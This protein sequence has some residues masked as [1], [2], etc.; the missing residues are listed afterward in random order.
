MEIDGAMRDIAIRVLRSRL[1]GAVSASAYN[2]VVQLAIQLASVPIL[3]GHLGLK[4]Y[5]IWL[6]LSTI[7]SY[8]AMADLGFASA[9]G[10]DMTMRVARDDV[11]GAAAV[12]LAL[13]L[14]VVSTVL[15]L[16]ACAGV[17]IY[18]LFPHM[19]DFAQVATGGS[20][21]AT[22]LALFGYGLM[23]LLSGIPVAGF[24]ATHAY[25]LCGYLWVTMTLLEAVCALTWVASG[26]GLLGAALAYLLVRSTGTL[27]LSVILRYHAPGLTTRD[28]RLALG[29]VRELVRPA[30]GVMALPVAQAIALQGAVLTI[31]AAAGPA[32]V[33]LFTT[34]RTL[35]RTALQMTMIVNQ[36]STP[37]FSVAE[38][39][40]DER[41]K[42]QLVLICLLV[43]G[44]VLVPTVPVLLGLGPMIIALWTHGAVHPPFLLLA[45]MSVAMLLNGLWMPVSNYILAINRHAEFSYYYVLVSACCVALGYPLAVRFG[46]AGIAFA[47]VLID[48]LMLRR[49]ARIAREVGVLNP[50][51]LRSE[52]AG[53]LV[54]FGLR[55]SPIPPPGRP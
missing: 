4:G 49:V 55:R 16:F 20:G 30:V 31:G 9:A 34:V 13:K 11:A 44:V 3:S 25:V 52:L 12:F 22:V 23:A 39:R 19:A 6:L 54:L 38:A 45:F 37:A 50:A 46:P 5:G 42:S 32:A 14:I 10:N 2:Q 7:P 18:V 28:W 53:G 40:G 24:K 27:L 17:A 51:A 33:P 21:Q 35:T 29:H 26:G 8:L 15:G 47:L 48:A 1:A 41:R 43:A 36:A